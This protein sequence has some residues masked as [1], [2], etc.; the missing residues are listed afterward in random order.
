MKRCKQDGIID[1]SHVAIDSA[2]IHAYEKKQPKKKS[3]QTGNVNWGAQSDSFDNKITWFG[4][5]SI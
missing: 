5:N 3:N 1:G 4:S 2:T